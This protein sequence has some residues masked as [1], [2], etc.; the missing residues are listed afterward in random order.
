MKLKFYQDPG[1]GWVKT[2]LKLL[3]KLGIENQITGFSYQRGKFA[4]LEED[5]DRATLLWAAAKAG[6]NIELQ[7]FHTNRDSRIRSYMRYC[8]PAVLDRQRLTQR[9]Q[10]LSGRHQA[11]N[12]TVPT[13]HSNGSDIETLRRDYAVAHEALLDFVV[14]LKAVQ[15]HP[16]DYYVQGDSA[17][18]AALAE[19]LAGMEE[20]E[21]LDFQLTK[22][23]LAIEEQDR[24][25]AA[26]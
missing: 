25:C 1:H 14:K 19:R 7:E 4:Y 13:V 15:F 2:P 17:W 22:I 6:I 12:V 23:R 10:D 18:S 3:T 5:F 26:C 16:R 9:L 11:V 21:K 24:S 8:P 20:L